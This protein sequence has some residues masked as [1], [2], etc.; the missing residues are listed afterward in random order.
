MKIYKLILIN[1]VMQ[2]EYQKKNFQKQAFQ[3]RNKTF[4]E[5]FDECA[6]VN[7]LVKTK[8]KNDIKIFGY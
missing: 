6:D 2:W 5:Y 3:K 1:F 7:E 8:F 4:M